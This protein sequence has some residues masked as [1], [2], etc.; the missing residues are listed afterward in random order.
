MQLHS[1][2]LALLVSIL[3]AFNGA[4]THAQNKELNSMAVAVSSDVGTV[5]E[6]SAKGT[7]GAVVVLDEIHTSRAGQI[8]QAIILTRLYEDHG[9][10]E[11]ALE[12]YLD[13]HPQLSASWFTSKATIQAR[14]RVATQFL[15]EGE[16]S[17]AE[18]LVLVFADAQLRRTE[19]RAEHNVTASN[20]S[21]A[22][23][24]VYLLKLGVKALSDNPTSH[25]DRIKRIERIGREFEELQES[26]SEEA[27]GDKATEYQRLLIGADPWAVERFEQLLDTSRAAQSL[28]TKKKV[29]RDINRRVKSKG[30]EL[31]AQERQHMD[32]YL[33][34]LDGR[35]RASTTMAN[36]V[37]RL[38]RALDAP[39]VAMVI[40]AGH[41]EDVL[42]ALRDN[43]RPY[44]CISP[45]SLDE[46]FKNADQGGLVGDLSLE[47][48]E[49]KYERL[50]VFSSGLAKT[51]QEEFPGEDKKK[52]E[53]VL[54]KHWFQAKGE[55]YLLVD[56][57]TQR[58]LG[59][60]SSGGGSGGIS[61][62]GPRS[63][64]L[65]PGEHAGKWI[66][67]DTERI[68]VV[69]D[70]EG[71]THYL[72]SREAIS[73]MKG[74]G[75]PATTLV[76]L[77]ELEGW[78]A[79][80]D[81]SFLRGISE[82]IGA[83]ETLAHRATILARS[84][85]SGRRA[86]LIPVI[87]NHRDPSKRREFW[88]KAMPG[89]PVGGR[90]ISARASVESWLRDALK[91]VRK[92]GEFKRKEAKDTLGRIQLSADTIAVFAN[93]VAAARKATLGSV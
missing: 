49:R 26:G 7:G 46:S 4:T 34:F 65:P 38:A 36:S 77:A 51:L 14:A 84:V 48:F 54:A 76:Q 53:P 5:N 27:L 8:E 22:A 43:N 92:Q 29:A 21:H 9:L 62:G 31:T 45:Q 24:L 3:A 64:Q 42:Q 61:G 91:D 28:A 37:L 2:L 18:F 89:R 75:L 83:E 73:R 85:V 88:V 39:P 87:L 13:D 25:S 30:V 72:L 11:V 67:I 15:R 68:A 10:R 78:S 66:A 90:D 55:L 58:L 81:E 86:L 32:E 1:V 63:H 50:S 59:P 82:T 6:V 52:P 47:L 19:K 16:I 33:A 12:A 35:D 41:T 44:A 60:T 70:G 40:G 56:N 74:D 71:G 93:T 17:S 69:G 80:T 23:P 57:V 79:D 20:E